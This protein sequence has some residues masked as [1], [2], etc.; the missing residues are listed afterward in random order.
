MDDDDSVHIDRAVLA[1]RLTEA[2]GRCIADMLRRDWGERKT[3]DVILN[4]R[5]AADRLS[6]LANA[7]LVAISRLEG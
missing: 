7:C 6:F 5:H 4:L 2:D 1:S 3:Q